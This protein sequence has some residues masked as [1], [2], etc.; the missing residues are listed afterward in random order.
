MEKFQSR[1]RFNPSTG[2]IEIEGSEE[3]V[4]SYFSKVLTLFEEAAAAEEEEE[5]KRPAP[6][7]RRRGRARRERPAREGEPVIRSEAVQRVISLIQ[8]SPD[9][10]TTKSLV[11]MTGLAERQVRTIVYRA[12]KRGLIKK[13]RRGL[14]RPA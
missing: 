10:V 8:E 6:E 4:N 7:K 5:E 12:E 14:Y 3:F 1:I 13:A 9:G 2:E 11:E